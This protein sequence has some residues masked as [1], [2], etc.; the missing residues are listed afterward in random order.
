[1]R[2]AGRSATSPDEQAVFTASAGPSSAL[3]QRLQPQHPCVGGQFG[4]TRTGHV[5]HDGGTAEVLADRSSVETEAVTLV[6]QASRDSGFAEED[7]PL[8]PPVLTGTDRAS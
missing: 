8:G 3:P 2:R 6:F 4:G 5:H 1:M 7:A